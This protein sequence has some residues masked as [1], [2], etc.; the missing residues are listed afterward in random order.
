MLSQRSEGKLYEQIATRVRGMI[1]ERIYRPGDRL[2]SVRE[3]SKQCGVSVTTVLDAYRLLEDQGL[4]HPRPQSGYYVHAYANVR[5]A[6]P[7][8]K[9]PTASPSLFTRDE[10]LSP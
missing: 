10:M 1:L 2:P 3:L 6:E 8:T 9:A 5:S 4:I 7:T